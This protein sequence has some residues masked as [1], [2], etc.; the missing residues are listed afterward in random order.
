MLLQASSSPP[1]TLP[2]YWWT[3]SIAADIIRRLNGIINFHKAPVKPLNFVFQKL[4]LPFEIHGLLT[5]YSEGI[6]ES[7]Q[8]AELPMFCAEERSQVL[9][10]VNHWTPAIMLA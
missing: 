7:Q 10:R 9:R 3:F 2:I 5:S 1:K 8:D 4:R 6:I